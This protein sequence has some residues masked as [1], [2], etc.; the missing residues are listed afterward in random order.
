MTWKD[1]N[2]YMSTGRCSFSVLL[3][4]STVAYTAAIYQF[5]WV[6]ESALLLGGFKQQAAGSHPLMN[7]VNY[8]LINTFVGKFITDTV[9]AAAGSLLSL[10]KPFNLTMWYNMLQVHK[11]FLFLNSLGCTNYQTLLAMISLLSYGNPDPFWG[12]IGKLAKQ[13]EGEHTTFYGLFWLAAKWMSDGFSGYMTSW[14]WFT[15]SYIYK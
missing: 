4:K 7:L 9:T 15:S 3:T 6:T 8:D 1:W 11:M 2:S 5:S 13:V 10:V 14:I 12:C